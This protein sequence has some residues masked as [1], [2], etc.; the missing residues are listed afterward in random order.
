MGLIDP[1]DLRR[2]VALLG[3]GARLFHG[4]LRENLTL[5]AP[6]ATDAAIMDML[7]RMSLVDFVE[8]LPDGLDHLV[9]EGGL[10]L[11]GGQKQGLLMA[12]ILLRDPNV[13]LLDEPTAAFDE[14]SEAAMIEMLGRLG[15]EKS[16][17]VATHRPAIL[18][19]VDRLIVVSNG[20]IAM[21]GPKDKVLAQL[22]GGEAAA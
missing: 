16:V 1:N 4:T 11:S 9:Q 15:P 2:D 17:I 19:I 13:L 10:G 20:R 5:G 6:D 22:R 12:R 14:V 3:Q 7:R 21:D 18:R 8:R